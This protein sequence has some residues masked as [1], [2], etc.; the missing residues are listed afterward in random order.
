MKVD[1]RLS[2]LARRNPTQDRSSRRWKAI[3]EAAA[4][5]IAEVGYERL[6]MTGIAARARTSAGSLYQYF[7]DKKAIAQALF[8]QQ[9]EEA[10]ERWKPLFAAVPGL[11]PAEIAER[12]VELLCS[13]IDERPAY[14]PLLIAPL[15]LQRSAAARRRLREQFAKALRAKDGRLGPEESLLMANMTF[16][17]LQGFGASY[18]RATTEERA[19]LV[20]EMKLALYAYVNIRLSA[21]AV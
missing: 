6:T 17:L 20:R 12:L 11:E 18:V 1:S 14:L 13:V 9:G 19:D 16:Q 21:K 2:N 10:Q 15:K 3:L 4:E 5:L 8:E 7:P